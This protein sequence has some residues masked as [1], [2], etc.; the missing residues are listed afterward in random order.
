LRTQ[1]LGEPPVPP[2]DVGDELALLADRTL[3]VMLLAHLLDSALDLF[4][5]QTLPAQSLALPV[6]IKRP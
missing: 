5:G 2:E 1:R 3:R 4:P 6:F